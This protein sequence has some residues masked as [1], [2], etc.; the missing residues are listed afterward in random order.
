MSLPIT[1][2]E[3]MLHNTASKPGFPFVT[4]DY[5]IEVKPGELVKLIDLVTFWNANHVT[6]EVEAKKN[7]RGTEEKKKLQTEQKVEGI[8]TQTKRKAKRSGPNN[9]KEVDKNGE[10]S[11]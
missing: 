3:S 2:L 1:M 6:I 5:L 11:S 9:K 10:L 4:D 7:D 8:Q